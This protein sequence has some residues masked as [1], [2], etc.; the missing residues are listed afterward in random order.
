MNLV[1]ALIGAV[2]VAITWPFQLDL[3][4]GAEVICA[5]QSPYNLLTSVL[6]HPFRHCGNI[7]P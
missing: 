4:D 5:L 1:A 6:T 7:A 3:D 2:I